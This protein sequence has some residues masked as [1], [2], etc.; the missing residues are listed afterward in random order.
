M[1]VYDGKIF[2]I[3]ELISVID[4]NIKYHKINNILQG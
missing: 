4:Q 3:L 1:I 2:M